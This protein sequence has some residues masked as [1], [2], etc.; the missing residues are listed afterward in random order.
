MHI[1][2]ISTSTRRRAPLPNSPIAQPLTSPDVSD[3]LA[4]VHLELPAGGAL[5]EHDHGAPHRSC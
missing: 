3:Q 1:A 5:P 4:V 2:E